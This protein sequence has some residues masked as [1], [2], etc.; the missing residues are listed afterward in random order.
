M[1]L[2]PNTI[3]H[4]KFSLSVSLPLTHTQTRTHASTHARTHARTHAH[5]H[6]H[7]CAH[8]CIIHACTSART[9]THRHTHRHTHTHTHAV[10]T[11]H[12]PKRDTNGGVRLRPFACPPR[13]DR[14]GQRWGHTAPTL[15]SGPSVVVRLLLP[16]LW[17]WTCR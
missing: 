8:I 12:R 2:W 3:N 13:E 7:A 5:T 1:G 4:L 17:A 6:T 11:D 9:H 10:P 14:E 15:L 16:S